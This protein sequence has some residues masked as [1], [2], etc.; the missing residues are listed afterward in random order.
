M[1]FILCSVGKTSVMSS[2]REKRMKQGRS[3]LQSNIFPLS[4]SFPRTGTGRPVPGGR[5]NRWTCSWGYFGER[6]NQ[7]TYSSRHFDE[8]TFTAYE[9]HPIESNH[10][11]C[12]DGGLSQDQEGKW[13]GILIMNEIVL[14]IDGD[15]SIEVQVN[16]DQ[17]TVWL[18]PTRKKRVSWQHWSW[19][20]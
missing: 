12:W 14:F 20:C 1:V 17:E 3:V 16:P 6:T 7:W 9:Q 2:V 8:H 5:T 18:T 4:D 15:K 19:I 13:G 11:W 10:S